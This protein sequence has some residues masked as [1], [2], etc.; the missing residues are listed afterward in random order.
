MSQRKC[1]CCGK[2]YD[3]CPNCGK[4]SSKPWMFSFDTEVC[5]ELFN[6]V[7]AYNMKLIKE[8][9]IKNIVDKYS[10]TD[11][12]IYKDDIKNLLNNLSKASK[13]EKENLIEEKAEEIPTFENELIEGQPRRGRRNRYFE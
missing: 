5:K 8:D 10:I 3:Y 13:P 4:S 7:S 1:K 12:S 2:S 9:G 11:F 6:A